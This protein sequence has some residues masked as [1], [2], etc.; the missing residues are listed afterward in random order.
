MVRKWASSK[1][2]AGC[3]PLKDHSP[4][5]HRNA[6]HLVLCFR[7]CIESLYRAYAAR[8]ILIR[9]P[10]DC[11]QFTL[12]TASWQTNGGF[13]G[14]YYAASRIQTSENS[15]PRTR[16]NKALRTVAHAAHAC[17]CKS[18]QRE[19]VL[20]RELVEHDRTTGLSCHPG[21]GAHE[22]APLVEPPSALVVGV[23]P[24][25]GSLE[26]ACP[27]LR[28]GG[29]DELTA[30]ALAPALGSDEHH[31]HD[32]YFG[33]ARTRRRYQGHVPSTSPAESATSKNAPVLRAYPL[34]GGGRRRSVT[35]SALGSPPNRKCGFEV[36]RMPAPHEGPTRHRGLLVG[37]GSE[38]LHLAQDIRRGSDSPRT[39]PRRAAANFA[40]STFHA[41]TSPLSARHIAGVTLAEKSEAQRTRDRYLWNFTLFTSP[42][43]RHPKSAYVSQGL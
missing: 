38:V 23:R 7:T 39:L 19:K 22:A 41:Q 10:M 15:L 4:A 26:P 29:V 6:A 17:A 35:S 36:L 2:F 14:C 11:G 27:R 18:G 37:P 24:Q 28:K 1:L 30:Y 20:E 5:E 21:P 25:L 8:C 33:R 16:V 3:V 42:I 34:H 31:L 32:R 13:R 12:L 43:S 9:D 40:E